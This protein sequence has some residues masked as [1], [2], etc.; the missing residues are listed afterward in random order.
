LKKLRSDEDRSL[1]GKPI[2]FSNFS[3]IFSPSQGH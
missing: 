2:L 3:H 1:T